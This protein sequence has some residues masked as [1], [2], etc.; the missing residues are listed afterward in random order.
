MNKHRMNL[1]EILKSP[2]L[3]SAPG[4]A[5]RLL[6][7]TRDPNSTAQELATTINSDPALATKILRSANSSLFNFRAEVTTVDRAVRLLGSTVINSLA[8][9]FSLASE[10]MDDPVMAEQYQR[11]WLRSATLAASAESLASGVGK[12]ASNLF[13]AGLLV[14]LGQLAMLKVFREKYASLLDECASNA[15]R[16]CELEIERIGCSHIE[17][18]VALM[19]NWKLPLAFVEATRYH[20]SHPDSLPRV[21]STDRLI[22]STIVASVAAEYILGGK[23]ECTLPHLRALTECYF[24]W[25]ETEMLSYLDRANQRARQAA[26]LLSAKADELPSAADLLAQATEQL[27]AIAIRQDREK[28]QVVSQQLIAEKQRTELEI[29]N[30]QLRQQAFRDPLTGVFNRRYF[31][32]AMD[33]ETRRAER[34]VG[35]VAVLFVDVDHFKSLNDTFGHACGDACLVQL[36]DILLK[37]VR[38]TDI[39]ARYGG[40][41]FVILALD[42]SESGL[43]TLAERIRNSVAETKLSHRENQHMITVSIGGAIAIPDRVNRNFRQCLMETADAAMYESK[44][45]GRNRVSIRSMVVSAR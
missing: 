20:H 16:Q 33:A 32:D 40:E 43:T 38:S 7:L 2:K 18:G 17:V 14:D 28:Q 15:V 1:N 37:C 4:V 10:A 23:S 25:S 31:E 29:Q 34:T 24:Q 27:A 6:E 11:Y 3:P 26:E 5:L 22:Q 39:V 21:L 41:E 12:D 8:L 9:S 35:T 19:E 45:N 42:A 30:K 13:V 36:A 44:R